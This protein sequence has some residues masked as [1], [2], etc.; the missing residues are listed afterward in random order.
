MLIFTVEPPAKKIKAR[1]T[2]YKKSKFET[3]LG[4]FKEFLG[5]QNNKQAKMANETNKQWLDLEKMKLE[6]EQEERERERQHELRLME[7]FSAMIQRTQAQPPA[8][9]HPRQPVYTEL[10]NAPAASNEYYRHFN[11]H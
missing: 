5:E 8:P 1:D 9:Q 6:K 3:A 7:M 4:N 11:F 2:R 10:Q